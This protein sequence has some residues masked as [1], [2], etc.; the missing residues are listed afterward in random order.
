MEAAWT[1]ETLVSY[2]NTTWRHNPEDGGS[3]DLG[4]VG[5]LPQHYMASK[6]RRWRQHGSLER[7][8]PTTLH[9]VTTQKMEAVWTSETLVSY[10]N[11]TRRHNAEDLDLKNRYCESMKTRITNYSSHVISFQVA[12]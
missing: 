12:L 10:H 11:I 2:H 8:Y 5:V 9:G 6:P 1:S 4:N 3:M 7:W